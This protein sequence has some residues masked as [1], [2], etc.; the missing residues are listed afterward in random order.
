MKSYEG[1]V[2]VIGGGSSG[3]AAVHRLLQ[4]GVS[5]VILV[6][7]GP[8]YGSRGGGAWPADV[9]DVR[10]IPASHD[11]G[12]EEVLADGAVHEHRR[13]KVLG[14]SSARNEAGAVWAL[15][16]DFD[17]WAKL[18]GDHSWSAESLRP[19]KNETESSS[20]PSPHH[21][22]GGPLRTTQYSNDSITPWG[23]AFYDGWIETGLPELGDLSDPAPEGGVAVWHA[24]IDETTRVNASFAFIDPHRHDPR[25]QIV[26]GTTADR[27]VFD[28]DRA[29]ALIGRDKSGEQIEI[30]G[31]KFILSC[32]AIG[33]PEV[34]LRSG[35]GPADEL[36]ELGIEVVA[37]VPGVGKRLQDHVGTALAYDLT[38]TA[39]SLFEQAC[40]EG[41][42]FHCQTISRLPNPA[43]SQGGHVHLLPYQVQAPTG[44]WLHMLIAWV[45][46][47]VSQGE[48]RLTS[49][50]PGSALSI[51]AGYYSDPAGKD[52]ETMAAS[53]PLLR[54]LADS[55][56]MSTQI[57]RESPWTSG[58]DGPDLV[59]A[60][61]LH[62]ISYGHLVGSCRIGPDDDPLA[63][64]DSAGRVR[65]T[66][67]VTV[68]DASAMP[69]IPSS[70]TNLTAMLLGYKLAGD[71]A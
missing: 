40:E 37:D 42:I 35:I 60:I 58:L 64:A 10:A 56:S 6:E 17:A 28:G 61:R 63:V 1:D 9:L 49:S 26:S 43:T 71:S 13:G 34:L 20:P 41:R 59:D 67:N 68:V 16:E 33:S 62:P 21:G 4:D 29:T 5:R 51:T 55:P 19:L 2:V 50:E 36:R 48:I 54:K 24:N 8:D 70:N 46:N 66:A 25:L 53:I 15:D 12:Y 22:D 23:R 27:L 44:E 65:G 3:C 7:A 45:M 31:G 39:Q 30:R 32:G 18:L 69:T 47:P 14:G 38:A 52:L 11:W 57:E